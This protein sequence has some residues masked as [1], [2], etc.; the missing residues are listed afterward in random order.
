MRAGVTHA[1]TSVLSAAGSIEI[2]GASR[3]LEAEAKPEIVIIV[4]AV[5]QVR[6][7]IGNLLFIC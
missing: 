7:R 4:S 3:W 1:H 2:A 5:K 6:S